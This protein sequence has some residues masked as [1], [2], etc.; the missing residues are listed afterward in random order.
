M[1]KQYC[2]V[3]TVT[4]IEGNGHTLQILQWQYTHF[5]SKANGNNVDSR[6]LEF[7]ES[8]AQK[9]KKAMEELVS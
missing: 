9:V 7:F 8:K 5:L 2:K 1:E 3:G 4:P 6:L